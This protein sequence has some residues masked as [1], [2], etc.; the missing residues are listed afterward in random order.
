MINAAIQH[1]IGPGQIQ[2]YN[3]V[4]GDFLKVIKKPLREL[5]TPLEASHDHF[6]ITQSSHFALQKTKG[7]VYE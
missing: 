3:I 2:I 7:S 1:F 4:T 5:R 6:L